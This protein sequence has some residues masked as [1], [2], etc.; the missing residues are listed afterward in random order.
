MDLLLRFLLVLFP[1]LCLTACAVTVS[2]AAVFV[3][4]QVWTSV[5]RT[6][7][8]SGKSIAVSAIAASVTFVLVFVLAYVTA[9]FTLRRQMQSP[10]F[11]IESPWVTFDEFVFES[12]GSGILFRGTGWM[13]LLAAGGCCISIGPKVG[14][15]ATPRE[16]LR[17]IVLSAMVGYGIALAV[18]TVCLISQ[19]PSS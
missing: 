1:I 13:S 10:R 2:V 3:F 17:S 14:R 16:L 6:R 9:W 19:G 11:F 12:E 5:R 18:V 4:K 15:I 8:A 7:A